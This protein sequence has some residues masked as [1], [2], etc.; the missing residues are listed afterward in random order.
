M[1]RSGTHQDRDFILC[2]NHKAQMP[3]AA[4]VMGFSYT[5]RTMQ[6]LNGDSTYRS[7]IGHIMKNCGL[8]KEMEYNDKL[9]RSSPAG[10][11]LA[12]AAG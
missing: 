5:K 3:T 12:P 4:Q 1:R 7:S 6:G 9:S 2:V 8:R 11:R 10:P